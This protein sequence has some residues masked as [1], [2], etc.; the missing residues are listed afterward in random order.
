MDFVIQ[1]AADDSVTGEKCIS[2]AARI[3]PFE[4]SNKSFVF[5]CHFLHSLRYIVKLSWRSS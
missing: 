4:T 2:K 1:R 5:P 3:L